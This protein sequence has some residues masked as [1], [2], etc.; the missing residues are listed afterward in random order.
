MNIYFILFYQDLVTGDWLQE[1]LHQLSMTPYNDWDNIDFSPNDLMATAH[2]LKK[3]T[4]RLA[5]SRPGNDQL[6]EQ[7]DLHLIM[8]FA[9]Q[10]F[11]KFYIQLKPLD[12]GREKS[13]GGF[14]FKYN[15]AVF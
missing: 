1:R 12:N 4:L 13:N 11:I 14:T 15:T 9:E 3:E 6:Q 7:R 5:V 2:E 8:N 10:N